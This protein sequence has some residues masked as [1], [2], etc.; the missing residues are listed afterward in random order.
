MHTNNTTNMNDSR[1]DGRRWNLRISVGPGISN[2]CPFGSQ[3]K[4]NG[5]SSNSFEPHE[6]LSNSET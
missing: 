1:V 3:Q 4:S 5:G 2:E 6:L